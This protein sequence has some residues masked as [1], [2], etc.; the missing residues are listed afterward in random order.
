[1][2]ILIFTMTTIIFHVLSVVGMCSQSPD[3][4]SSYKGIRNSVTTPFIRIPITQNYILPTGIP[5]VG[6]DSFMSDYGYCKHAPDSLLYGNL[7]C[8]KLTT[9]LT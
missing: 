7:K 6:Q 3:W 2:C 4:T 1:M 5:V 8:L 9:T